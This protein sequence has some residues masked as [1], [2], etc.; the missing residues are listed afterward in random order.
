ME[1][2]A[3]LLDRDIRLEDGWHFNSKTQHVSPELYI[4]LESG[5]TAETVERATG[6]WRSVKRSS[7]VK[8][9]APTTVPAG[10]EENGS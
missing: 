9:E 2:V 10:E 3:C 5:I 8:Q 4:L 1:N 7:M 6:S